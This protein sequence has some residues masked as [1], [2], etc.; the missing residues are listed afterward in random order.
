MPKLYRVPAFE[1]QQSPPILLAAIDGRWLLKHSTPVW[2]IDDPE[3]GF[4]RIVRED[5][6][7][8]IAVNVL[9]QRRTFPNTIVLATNVGAL[10]V[11]DGE[12]TLPS[13]IKFL[14]VDGQHRLW[15]Q[16]FSTYNAI[17]GCVIHLGLS[18][19]AMARLFLEINDN[20]KRV[21]SSLR[22][23]L[24]RLVRPDDDPY[25][26]EA[27]EL[28]YELATD[29]KSPLYQRIDL[30]GEQG[31]IDIK[32]GSIAPEIKSLVASRKSTLRGLGFEGQYQALNRFLSALKATDPDGWRT[33]RSPFVKARVLRAVLRTM[34][35]IAAA[36]GKKANQVAARTYAE[37]LSRVERNSLS[38]DAIR[39]VQGSAGIKEIY[40]LIKDQ[41]GLN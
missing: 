14:V 20:Q 3:K 33:A 34:P 27:V 15:A 19:V 24:V 31:E 18:E 35:D 1:L 28:V 10:E 22:W 26:V 9:D 30:T 32:Q 11:E 40:D 38:D 29:E 2:R 37:Y 36:E 7:R 6:A 8:Q 12:I 4:Q 25:A 41:M 21:P 16:K 17:Y 5:R 39:A 23:D 13:K